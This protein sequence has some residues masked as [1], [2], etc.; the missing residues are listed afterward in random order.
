[1]ERK[2]QERK[3]K[4]SVRRDVFVIIGQR[5][6]YVTVSKI[7]IDKNQSSRNEVR[8]LQKD[9]NGLS[10]MSRYMVS[11]SFSCSGTAAPV[12]VSAVCVRDDIASTLLTSSCASP[13]RSLSS[14]L[15]AAVSRR[16]TTATVTDRAIIR[17]PHQVGKAVE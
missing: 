2:G 9:E 7:L 11:N 17:M 6:P 14:P 15:T 5:Q 13:W 12:S 16:T 3:R 10:G 4:V 8:R 1:M